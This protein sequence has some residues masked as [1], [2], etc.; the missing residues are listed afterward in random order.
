MKVLVTGASGFVGAAIATRLAAEGH[1]VRAAARGPLPRSLLGKVEPAALPDLSGP[2]DF[3]PLCAG[4][5]VIVHAAGLAH[6]PAGLDEAALM[7]VNATGAAR[8]AAAARAR[9]VS[10]FLL[11]SSIR[12][13]SGASAPAPLA[14][15]IAATPTDA[16][17]RSKRAGEDEVAAAFPGAMILRPPVVHGAGARGNMARLARAARWP[18]PLPLAGLAGRRSVVSDVNLAAAV[19]CLIDHPDAKGR[20]FHLA[21]GAPL[22]VG[23]MVTAMRA[24]LGRPPGLFALPF[25]TRLLAT[26]APGM[27]RQLAGDLIV[28][29]G[30][31]RAL[32]WRPVEPSGDGLARLVL[33]A[34]DQTRL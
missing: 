27:A 11:V 34:G 32:G 6:Q 8:L 14:E 17:G 15:D 26:L 13:I 10:A 7:A 16:Y 29:D 21:D 12:A 9:G 31:L 33:A 24:A 3:G 20:A 1:A 25:A 4:M 30:A 28:D 18:V 22:T 2:S 5:E 19:V 23:D